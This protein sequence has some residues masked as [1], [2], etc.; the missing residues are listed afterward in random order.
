M[1]CFCCYCSDAHFII[2]LINSVIFFIDSSNSNSSRKVGVP[3]GEPQYSFK[4]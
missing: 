2:I 3:R 1:Q 4:N